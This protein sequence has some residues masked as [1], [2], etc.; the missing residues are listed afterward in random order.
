MEVGGWRL[1]W[2][3]G[4]RWEAGG[5]ANGAPQG[6]PSCVWRH[7]CW[8]YHRE[9]R[10]PFPLVPA[11]ERPHARGADRQADGPDRLPPGDALPQDTTPTV[12]ARPPTAT[13]AAERAV[14]GRAVRRASAPA[15]E[16]WRCAAYGSPET[17]RDASHRSI[18]RDSTQFGAPPRLRGST[19]E[20]TRMNR[21]GLAVTR[22]ARLN[23]A[24]F[25]FILLT[26]MTSCKKDATGSSA[27]VTCSGGCSSMGWGIEG[28]SGSVS[29]SE[30]CTRSY[31]PSGD[32]IETC[33]G[34]RTYSNSGKTYGYSATFDWPRCR[35]VV[36][37][38]NVGSCSDPP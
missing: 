33:T 34:S 24:W 35:I 9:S 29:L 31:T 32:Y 18:T 30:S 5:N 3:G 11:Y 38:T 37:V 14:A 17:P 36:S 8:G 6:A 10:Q 4:W 21:R 1:E 12:T 27:R 22:H 16:R 23:F 15:R 25:L 28:E 2:E 26:P 7:A 20:A 19:E 13:P